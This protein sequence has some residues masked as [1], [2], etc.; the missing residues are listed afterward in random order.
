MDVSYSSSFAV[1]E[2][3]TPV[4]QMDDVYYLLPTEQKSSPNSTH[5]EIDW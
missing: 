4:K 5:L 1:L 2:L 3:L